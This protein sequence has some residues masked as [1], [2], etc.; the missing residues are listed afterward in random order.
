MNG[1]GQEMKLKNN[2]GYLQKSK[3]MDSTSSF[4]QEQPDNRT[5]VNYVSILTATC[6]GR[7]QLCKRQ[8]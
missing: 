8:E 4:V 3:G 2:S 6:K 7:R 5:L 1:M